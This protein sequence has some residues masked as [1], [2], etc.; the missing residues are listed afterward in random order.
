MTKKVTLNE[1]FVKYRM[2]IIILEDD[3]LIAYQIE[4]CVKNLGHDVLACF[5]EASLA[6]DFIADNKPDFVFMDAFSDLLQVAVHERCNFCY[7][8]CSD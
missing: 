1:N 8:H 6:L 7:Y 4:S 5:D 2:K 3:A